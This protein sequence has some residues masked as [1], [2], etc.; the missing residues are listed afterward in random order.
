MTLPRFRAARLVAALLVAWFLV[1]NTI[2][3]LE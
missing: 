1:S 2:Q 3:N